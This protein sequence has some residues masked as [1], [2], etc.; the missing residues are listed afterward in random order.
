MLGHQGQAA[1][2][3]PRG[4]RARPP[5]D[6]RSWIDIPD[7]DPEYDNDDDPRGIFQQGWRGG[8]TKFNRLEGCWY[9]EDSIYFVSTSG[10]DA[11]NGDVNPDGYAEGYGQVWEYRIRGRHAA[12]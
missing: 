3:R 9:G 12:G 6:R 1:V 10:G 7:P 2:R 5:A 11:K 8:G 4:A